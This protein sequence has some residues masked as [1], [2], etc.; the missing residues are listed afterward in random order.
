MRDIVYFDLETQRSFGDVGGYAHKEKMGVSVGVVYSTRTG[1]YHIFGENQMDVLIDMLLKADLVVGY[2]HIDFDYAVLQKYT[3]LN[4]TD[5][6]LNLDMLNTVEEKLGHRLKLDALASASLG[7]G[8][9]ADG[10]DALRWWQ[11]YKK[12]GFKNIE[13]MMKIA[14]YCCY[15]VKVTKEVHEYGVKNGHIKYNDK[16][17][18]LAQFEVDWA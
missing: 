5:A 15:D 17:G 14:E 1:E 8:K 13:P 7:C 12:S 18:G 3:I 9:T 10:L 6:T 4:L 16:S 2:N 11:D